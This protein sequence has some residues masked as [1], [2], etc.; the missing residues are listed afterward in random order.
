MCRVKELILDVCSR[1]EALSICKASQIS[2]KIKYLLRQEIADREI[3]IRYIHKVLP[4]KYK[5]SYRS[6]REL[7]SLYQ[8]YY[9]IK[10]LTSARKKFRVLNEVLE[11][12]ICIPLRLFKK[13]FKTCQLVFPSRFIWFK[14][15]LD[16]KE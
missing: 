10:T 7:I 1:I 2:T 6:K 3:T 8:D 13:K 9:N 4:P 5:R 11:C 16:L 14:M 12:Q 15:D